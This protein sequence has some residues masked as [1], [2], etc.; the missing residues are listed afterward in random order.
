ME[1]ANALIAEPIAPPEDLSARIMKQV[2]AEAAAA[3]KKRRH[4]FITLATTLATAAL[5][6]L[7]IFTNLPTLGFNGMESVGPD[8]SAESPQSAPSDNASSGN[9][10]I[11]LRPILRAEST[12]P[13]SIDSFSPSAVEAALPLVVVFSADQ[14]LTEQGT[15]WLSDI[16]VNNTLESGA[17]VNTKTFYLRYSAAAEMAA[18]SDATLLLASEGTPAD[19]SFCLVFVIERAE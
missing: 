6:A 11:K 17:A 2:R 18:E 10:D 13:I 3:T 12:T 14:D 15:I 4:R 19:D 8:S 1:E 16:F 9:H 5:L 7:V